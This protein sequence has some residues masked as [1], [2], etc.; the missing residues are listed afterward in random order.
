MRFAGTIVLGL[1]LGRAGVGHAQHDVLQGVV[2]DSVTQ[3]PLAGV[4]VSADGRGLARTDR[5]GRFTLVW[6]GRDSVMVELELTGY[7]HAGRVLHRRSGARELYL[8]MAQEVRALDPIT[9]SPGPQ[10][11]YRREDLHVA[12]FHANEDGLWVLVYER[13]GLWH[14]ETEVGTPLF[15]G[16]RLHLLDTLFQ[17]QRMVTLP[18]PV[19][20]L[21]HDHAG[22]VFVE[23]E[24]KAWRARL[25]G[26]GIHLEEFGRDALH[27]MVLPWTDSI[28][29]RLLGNNLTD[30]Y[31]AFD[32][33]AHDPAT[34]TSHVICSVSDAHL[35]GLFRSQYKYMSGRDK[36]IAM[37][38]ALALGTDAETVAGYMT[39]FHDDI[40][41]E[42]PYAPLF[43]VNDTLCVF[44]RYKGSIRC[45]GPDLVSLTDVPLAPERWRDRWKRL[46]QDR[47][48]GT[49]HALY[50]QGPRTWLRNVDPRSGRLDRPVVLEHPFPEEVQVHGGY[51]YYVYR[52]Y[53]SLQR[54]TLYR[55]AL[56]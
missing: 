29:G 44:D 5:K 7:R 2:V 8:H 46:V 42:K 51:A 26:S 16:A 20:A 6:A 24:R 4:Q 49:V 32:H 36:V 17:E 22:R 10:E 34:A 13:P 27:R 54:R 9:V 43:V 41:Y 18:G 53:G 52:P 21:Y 55:E 12:A 35:L 3:E 48:D 25:E 31:P 11:V 14:S 30:T 40:Y 56:R 50:T 15:R 39:A 28:P 37:D 19:R 23:G 47:V 45:F 38:L 1:L 33:I